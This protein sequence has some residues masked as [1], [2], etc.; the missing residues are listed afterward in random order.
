MNKPRAGDR[1]LMELFQTDDDENQEFEGFMNADVSYTRN[2][3]S[4]LEI[5]ANIHGDVIL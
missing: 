4:D 3:G 5:D 1:R 2:D